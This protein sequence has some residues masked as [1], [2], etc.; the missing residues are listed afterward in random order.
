MSRPV[1][2]ECSAIQFGAYPSALLTPESR[3]VLPKVRSRAS[4]YS[5]PLVYRSDASLSAFVPKGTKPA[6]CNTGLQL[7]QDYPFAELDGSG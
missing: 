7:D 1:I 3:I 5:R 2:E 6:S 4:L